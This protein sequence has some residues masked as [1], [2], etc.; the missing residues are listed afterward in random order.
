MIDSAELRHAEQLL[1]R[2]IRET[3]ALRDVI[4]GLSRELEDTRRA[5]ESL[6][7]QA[8]EAKTK[9]ASTASVLSQHEA[10]QLIELGIDYARASAN[11]ENV[12]SSRQAFER[13][14]YALVAGSSQ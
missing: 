10:K 13:A 11:D 14:V 5:C 9:V 12:T 7:K 6:R 1:G 8:A 2:A 3:E 4:K